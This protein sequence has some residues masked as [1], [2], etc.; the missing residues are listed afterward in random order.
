MSWWQ[1]GVCNSAPNGP[2]DLKFCMWGS[3]GRYIWFLFWSRSHDLYRGQTCSSLKMRLASIE[4]IS[5]WLEQKSYGL[6]C[7]PFLF[8]L[9]FPCLL[10]HAAVWGT[11]FLILWLFL[12]L[13]FILSTFC[14][15]FL[16]VDSF[17]PKFLAAW[18]KN[19]LYRFNAAWIT[20]ILS[21]DL[22]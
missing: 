13:E 15:T 8:F 4:V 7:P 5:P 17:T 1:K 14:S 18:I 9:H 2:N 6:C 3:F 19:I 21:I 10:F 12:S 16:S 20:N 22:I 11:Q